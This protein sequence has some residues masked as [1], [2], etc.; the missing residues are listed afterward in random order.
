MSRSQATINPRWDDPSSYEGDFP[1]DWDIRR[2][3]VY[4]RDQWTCTKCGTQSGPHAG[5]DGVPLH[6]HHVQPRADGGSNRLTNLTTLCESC[7][8]ALHG[9]DLFDSGQPQAHPP[10]VERLARLF[11]GIL[12]RVLAVVV[13]GLAYLWAI[14]RLLAPAM[15]WQTGLAAGFLVSIAVVSILRPMRLLVISLGVGLLVGGFTNTTSG[16]AVSQVGL[17]IGIL[18]LPAGIA[19]A[20][21]LL[22]P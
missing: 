21:L 19:S 13:G 8:T 6:A 2:R 15:T 10:L 9:H 5:S 18:W 12:G 22:G 4:E 1:P 14:E 7:H 17:L 16:Y 3:A 20:R 11:T